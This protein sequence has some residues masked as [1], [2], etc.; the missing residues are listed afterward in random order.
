MIDEKINE[1]EDLPFD[2]DDDVS[3]YD[4]SEEE[5]VDVTE[6]M[7]EEIQES[8]KQLAELIREHKSEEVVTPDLLEETVQN[9]P[10]VTTNNQP[11]TTKVEPN[12]VANV[13]DDFEYVRNNMIQLTKDGLTIIE[14]LM[15]FARSAQHP[16]LYRE[17]TTSLKEVAIINKSILE[18]HKIKNELETKNS[19]QPTNVHNTQN[20]FF[21]TTEELLEM[22]SKQK[23]INVTPTGNKNE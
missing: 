19:D 14:D 4:F 3:D 9:N 5:A 10:V 12:K 21:G 1:N 7:I 6:F 18:I 17:L 8:K 2:P 15:D 20:N 23:S 13:S 22:I 16:Q 11:I